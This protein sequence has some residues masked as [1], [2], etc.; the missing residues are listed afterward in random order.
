MVSTRSRTTRSSRAEPAL[1]PSASISKPKT[2]KTT[3]KPSAPKPEPT[4]KAL[5]MD[6]DIYVDSGEQVTFSKLLEAPEIK[7]LVMFT[8]PRASTGGCTAQAC[9]LRDE[10]AALREKGYEV[11]GVSYDKVPAQAKWKAKHEFGFKLL[12]DTP[13]VGVV[14][15]L[16]AHKPPKSVKRGVYI[17]GKEGNVKWAK[18]GVSPKDTVPKVREWMEENAGTSDTEEKATDEKE[19]DKEEEKGDE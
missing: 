16:G 5:P 4:P 8:Y 14:K 2:P 10:A 19:E 15:K 7:G 1:P 12:S 3:A 9:S 17:I 6:L 13:D 11:V 18:V